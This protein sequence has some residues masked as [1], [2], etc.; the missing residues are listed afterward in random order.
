MIDVAE[1]TSSTE[2]TGPAH[3]ETGNA[4]LP[5]VRNADQ[6]DLLR[7]LNEQKL[8]RVDLVIPAEKL[9][10]ENGMIIIEGQDPIPDREGVTDPNGAYRPTA[11]FDGQVAE[12]LGIASAYLRR[13]RFGRTDSKSGKQISPPRLDLWDANVNGLLHGRKPKVS[14][15]VSWHGRPM[16]EPRVLREGVPADPRSFFLRLLRPDNG[17]GIARAM[18]S[19]VYGAPM[20]NWNGLMSMVDGIKA[21]GVNPETLRITGDLSDNN[22]YIDVSAPEILVAAP[23]LL[24]GY[25][26]PFDTPSEEA[27]RQGSGYDLQ[28]RIDMGRKWLE[29]GARGRGHHMF[30]PGTEP[31]LH[32]GFQM[33]NSETG[34]GRWSIRPKL[35]VLACTNGLTLDKSEG[36][37]KSHVGSRMEAG[38]V[39]WAAD[40]LE[41]E[42]EWISRQTRDIVRKALSP[43]Y[44]EAQ[45]ADLTAKAGKQIDQPE[46][47]IQAVAKRFLFTAEQEKGILEYMLRAGQSTSGGVMQAVT[48]YSQTVP[49]ADV[50]HDLDDKAIAAMEFAYSM[51]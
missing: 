35:T 18:L 51:S 19:D 12:K 2:R 40:T 16:P 42:L 27:K 50:A 8:W 6:S 44:V 29:S 25:R 43:D 30:A 24:E 23:E 20:D 15:G 33:R 48:S 37:E 47:V 49:D 31:L 46:R 11:T 28:Q 9:R 26:S 41:A 17:L 21:A 45:I 13:L 3:D 22:M 1:A 4:H 32:A 5:R 10:F 36:F 39:V 7:I 14:Q 34:Q 38:H